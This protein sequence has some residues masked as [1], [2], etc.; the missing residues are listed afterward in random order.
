MFNSW[1]HLYLAWL[2]STIKIVGQ[3]YV[4]VNEWLNKS[5]AW[6]PILRWLALTIF[7]L[8][9]HFWQV[10][11][12]TWQLFA[13]ILNLLTGISNICCFLFCCFTE[14][15]FLLYII[16]DNQLIGHPQ[17]WPTLNSSFYL[18]RIWH[19]LREGSHAVSSKEIK[20]VTD[21]LHWSYRPP[22]L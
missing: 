18:V 8:E 2:P 7:N 22:M 14:R 12:R 13:H 6:W 20:Y 11:T 15:H 3:G 17:K 19:L 5:F 1:C 9:L 21:L 4:M 10:I 16:K